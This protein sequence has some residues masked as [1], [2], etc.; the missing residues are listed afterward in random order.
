MTALVFFAAFGLYLSGASPSIAPRDSADMA[1]A[2]LTLSPAHP[3]GYP[4]Y[5]ILGHAWISVFPL[6][7]P[8]YRLSVLSCLAG[9]GAVALVFA[10]VRRRSGLPAALAA[11]AILAL[12]A[13]L[14]KFSLLQEKYSLH[15]LF[16]AALYFLSGGGDASFRL[17]A[18]LFGLGLV[19]HQSLLFF[20]PALLLLWRSQLRRWPEWLLWT[21]V[22]LTPN[23]FL[24]IRLGSLSEAVAVAL[25]AQ[26]GTG[27]LSAQ[28]ARPFT[29]EGALALGAWSLKAWALA[30]GVPVAAAA[31]Y[32]AY[33]ADKSRASAL[34]LG[35]LLSG[36]LFIVISGFDPSNWVA[37]SVLEPAF[38]VPCLAAAVLAAES[39]PV[40]A[41]ALAASFLLPRLPVPDRRDDFLALDYARNLRRAV[42]PGGALLAGGHRAVR[43]ALARGRRAALRARRARGRGPRRAAR[44]AGRA[45]RPGGRFRLRARPGDA[46]R[47]RARAGRARPACRRAA[48]S[49]ARRPA[50]L[51]VLAPRRELRARREA[52]LRLRRLVG[53]PAR[54]GARRR[55]ARDARPVRGRARSRRLPPRV[56]TTP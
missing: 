13:P 7:N 43:R 56:A 26:Y 18:F 23:L 3:P 47:G 4:L 41:L 33:R 19:N 46:S 9:A 50:P 21:A 17:S 16:V 39:A 49:R 54:R 38:I 1:L 24:W 40:A 32:G 36:P 35:A 52:L 30:V 8:A 5:S 44:V 2:A 6:G 12:C 10:A 11:A 31:A 37:R 45:L 15:A 14:W 25:R 34:L 29:P 53:R 22:G 51:R 28:L 27:T 55:A 42:P 20:L 48:S